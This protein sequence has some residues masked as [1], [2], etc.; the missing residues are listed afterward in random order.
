MV[1]GPCTFKHRDVAAA[2][3]A[4]FKAGAAHVRV[5][6]D[7]KTGKMLVHVSKSEIADSID[8]NEWDEL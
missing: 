6:I 2:I 4:G 5:E 8:K 3:K 7:K 1:R